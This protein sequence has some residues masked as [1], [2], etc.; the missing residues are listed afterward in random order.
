MIRFRG[1]LYLAEDEMPL[2]ALTIKHPWLWC[3]L[4]S[5]KRIENRTWQ[6]PDRIVGKRIYLHSS[7]QFDHDGVAFCTDQGVELPDEYH[8]GCIEGSAIVRGYVR[9]SSDRWFQGPLGW[10]LEDIR[11]L[12]VPLPKRGYQGIWKV[13]K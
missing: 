12:K 3:I 2:Y 6:P 1:K 10:V 4:H 13:K 5:V 7:K 8:F 9:S 11:V